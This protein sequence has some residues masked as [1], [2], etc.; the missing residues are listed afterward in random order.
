MKKIFAALLFF[1]GTLTF[2]QSSNVTAIVTDSDGQSWNNGTYQI[3]FIPPSGYTGSVYTFN[4][5]PWTPPSSISGSLTGSGGFTY[6][7]LPRNDYILPSGSSW[8]FNFCPNASWHCSAT[9]IVINTASQNISSSIVLV[10]PRFPASNFQTGSFGYADGEISPVP[11]IG[12]GYF[13][14]TFNN[15][16]IWTGASW[17]NGAGTASGVNQIIPG[18]NITVSPSG[19]TGNVTVNSTGGGSFTYPSTGLVASTG[20]AWRT[21]TFSDV[22]IL[23]ASGSCSGY[24]KSDGTCSTPVSGINQLTGDIT[25][26]PGTGSQVGTLATVNS[27]PG[28]CGDSTHVC[29][30]TTNGKGLTTSQTAVS[31]GGVGGN[32][33]QVNGV[34][35]GGSV[36]NLNNSVPG[37]PG[38]DVAVLWQGDGS[39]HVSA[40]VPSSAVGLSLPSNTN[41][42]VAGDSRGIIASSCVTSGLDRG[43]ITSGIVSG[44]IAT[45]QTTNN[46]GGANGGSSGNAIKLAGFTGSYVALNGQI[47]TLASQTGSQIVAPVTGVSDGSTGTGRQFCAYNMA[48][49]LTASPYMP[50]SSTVVNTSLPN[51][52]VGDLI[53]NFT[54]IFSPY[55][56]ATTSKSAIVII[57]AGVAEALGCTSAGPVGTP[58]T[59]EYEY[60]QL[61]SLFAA[62]NMQVMQTS[63]ITDNGSIFCSTPQVAQIVLTTNQWLK[64]Q[65]PAA[66]VQTGSGN[67]IPGWTYYF[68]VAGVLPDA[69]NA[70][71]FINPTGQTHLTDEGNYHFFYGIQDAL[72]FGG[73][74]PSPEYCDPNLGEACQNGSAGFSGVSADSVQVNSTSDSYVLQISMDS[75]NNVNFVYNPTGIVA[76]TVTVMTTTYSG[77]VKTAS[78]CFF[79]GGSSCVTPDGSIASQIDIG[80]S[81]TGGLNFAY[82]LGPSVAP[83]VGSSC[84]SPVGR[85]VNSQDGKASYCSTSTGLWTEPFAPSPVIAS[86]SIP[87]FSPVSGTSGASNIT[88]SCSV[89]T[90]YYVS[91]VIPVSAVPTAYSTPINPSLPATL[92]AACICSACSTAI[93][94]ASYP[95]STGFLIVNHSHSTLGTSPI[96]LPSFSAS[97][98]NPSI[99]VVQEF[100]VANPSSFPVPTDTAGN[101]YVDAGPG[102]ATW[103]GSADSMEVFYAL[104]THTTASNVV[105]ISASSAVSIAGL[106]YEITGGAT[107]SPIDGGS[108]VGYSSLSNA[109]GGTAGANSLIA[110]SITPAGNGDLI[111]GMFQGSSS[112]PTAGTSPNTFTNVD[113]GFSG[114]SEYL[115]QATSAAIAA[116]AGDATTGDGY[117]AIVVAIKP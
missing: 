65:S 36:T 79:Q 96:S 83:T 114:L 8:L 16:R 32:P 21:P 60:A 113:S 77:V 14:V 85:W 48:G 93:A 1:V 45:F 42:I 112:G 104:N 12:N 100:A 54:S 116:T 108:G 24:L 101:T 105:T 55:Y 115:T 38:G 78:N 20:T 90:P 61:W 51:E 102:K 47:I 86:A 109:T 75:G 111:L 64:G 23:W 41:Y 103:N 98:T 25:A 66:I 46:Y 99:I 52:S 71:Y 33:V 73:D 13:N 40:Y 27:S 10:A 39:G 97:L 49:L 2:A 37:V 11:P 59:I 6:N 91:G 19:G 53:T 87:V 57:Q 80:S 110:S 107:S 74:I 4:G 62:H 44:G 63:I 17:I 81:G 18:T 76:P 15:S 30:V 5:S 70:Q 88:I 106:A 89:G 22:V 35:A 67:T 117:A 43:N 31:I 29:Q 50:S 28:S 94:T 92:G 58:G 82:W 68:D 3:A 9:T 7:S 34:A 56:P 69:S 95:A 84:G 72:L 26:G